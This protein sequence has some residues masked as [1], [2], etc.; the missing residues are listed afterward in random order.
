MEVRWSMPDFAA[1]ASAAWSRHRGAGILAGHVGFRAD[2]FWVQNR[3]S[4]PAFLPGLLIFERLNVLGDQ[5][6]G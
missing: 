3:R 2:V 1:S 5:R 4:E 6:H